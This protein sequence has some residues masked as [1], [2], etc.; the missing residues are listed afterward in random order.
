MSAA[1]LRGPY[2]GATSSTAPVSQA[3]VQVARLHRILTAQLLRHVG[4]HPSQELVMMQLWNY[5]PQRQTDLA[6]VVGADSATMTRTIQRLE[7]GGFV[8]RVPSKSDRRVT[9]VEPTLASRALRAEVERAWHELENGVTHGLSERE[10]H[11][12]LALF[13]RMEQNLARILEGEGGAAH[14]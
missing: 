3:I 9:I 7:H 6:K 10:R 5:G 13:T 8:R 11:D 1:S 2:G 12:V 14:P 4:L